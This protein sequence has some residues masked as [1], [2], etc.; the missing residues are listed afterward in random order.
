MTR[1]ATW[2]NKE[3]WW[4]IEPDKCRYLGEHKTWLHT[5][6]TNHPKW[7]LMTSSSPFHPITDWGA[8]VRFYDWYDGQCNNSTTTQ[9]F[10]FDLVLA[11]CSTIFVSF[12]RS[13]HTM[14]THYRLTTKSYFGRRTFTVSDGTDCEVIHS[15]QWENIFFKQEML[16]KLCTINI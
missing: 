14:V 4:L 13:W 15:G 3:V 16:L 5:G 12:R 11:K 2:C 7:L 8:V 10:H 1:Q 6:P 9:S